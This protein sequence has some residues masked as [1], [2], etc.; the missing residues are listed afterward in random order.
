M[1]LG[2]AKDLLNISFKIPKRKLKKLCTEQKG[3]DR[4]C[5]QEINDQIEG[6]HAWLALKS[7]LQ[8]IPGKNI[9][10]MIA[11]IN[12]KDVVVKVQ[13][14]ENTAREFTLSE[15][16]TG[17]NYGVAR[18]AQFI[19]Y[20]CMFTCGGNEDYIEAFG[21]V[22][23][24]KGQ[25]CAIKGDSMGIILMPYYDK[26]SFES[27]K[28]LKWEDAIEIL[29]SVL[30]LSYKSNISIGFVHGDLYLKNILINET[31]PVIIDFEKSTFNDAR[32]ITTFWYD[33]EGL[34]N[35]FTRYY[36]NKSYEIDDICRKHVVIPHAY[37]MRASEKLM[38]DL[39]SAL[40]TLK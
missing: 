5:Q 36:R 33:I 16:L 20:T 11:S 28:T 27:I 2:K 13:S 21:E 9:A 18:G 15:T 24:N 4:T 19:K 14:T 1:I 30:E 6:Q 39:I 31:K 35:D 25:I 38:D 12:S 40:Q 29:C 8:N 32:M 10:T 7:L 22:T 34:L 23:L 26:G 3:G 37:N 17:Y